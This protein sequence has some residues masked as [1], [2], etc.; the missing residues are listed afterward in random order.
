MIEAIEKAGYVPGKDISISLD[1][2]ASDLYRDGQYHFRLDNKSFTSSE[3]VE[4]M[5]SWCEKYHVISIEDPLADDD[6]SSWV[7]FMN[8]VGDTTQVVGDDLYTTNIGRIKDG[9]EAKASNSVLI[10]LNQIGSVSE[11]LDAI[12]L[13]QDVGWLPLVSARS[14]ETEDAF[15]SHLSV[16]VNAGQLKVGSFARS[17][18][19]IKWNEVLRIE[20]ALGDAARFEGAELFKVN[21]TQR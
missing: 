1:I 12:R 13:T 21:T 17:E 15:I 8:R 18:R 7:E 14:G 4:L 19:M 5:A 10:K 16:A 9:I 3:F 11:T 2:A 20:R 6:L